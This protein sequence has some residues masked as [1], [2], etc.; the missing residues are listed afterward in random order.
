MLFH[1]PYHHYN[2][3]E[4]LCLQILKLTIITTNCKHE[5]ALW[6]LKLKMFYRVMTD[7]IT[8]AVII[9]NRN[10]EKGD[11]ISSTVPDVIVSVSLRKDNRM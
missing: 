7:L 3:N 1:P 8:T 9:I 2:K 6:P 4:S 5:I 10:Y 11:D